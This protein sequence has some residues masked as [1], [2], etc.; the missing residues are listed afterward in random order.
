MIFHVKLL[1]FGRVRALDYFWPCSRH[2]IF[3]MIWYHHVGMIRYHP[4]FVC[5]QPLRS[6]GSVIRKYR[7][8]PKRV[9]GVVRP[10]LATAH[11]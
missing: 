9:W 11:G 5:F 4:G 2:V 6:H 3:V 7:V 8:A 10:V 1:V